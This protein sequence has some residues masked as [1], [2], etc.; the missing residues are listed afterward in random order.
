M[1]LLSDEIDATVLKF[2]LF[3]APEWVNGLSIQL[4]IS[5]Q[6][7]ISSLWDQA[8]TQAPCSAEST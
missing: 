5:A 7:V 2:E 4:L 1:N 8:P 3:V 6:V